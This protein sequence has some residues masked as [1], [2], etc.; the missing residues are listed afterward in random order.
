MDGADVG[1]ALVVGGREPDVVLVGEA[2]LDREVRAQAGGR[3]ELRGEPGVEVLEAVGRLDVGNRA[4]VG[5][6]RAAKVK[7]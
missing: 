2:D 5:V 6:L 4:L 7:R 1:R 3:V